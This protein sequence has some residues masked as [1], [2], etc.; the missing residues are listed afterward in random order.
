[1]GF[2]RP[3]GGPEEGAVSRRTGRVV[4]V[5]VR[6]PVDGVGGGVAVAG[7]DGD[8]RGGDGLVRAVGRAVDILH[9]L[10]VGIGGGGDIP[11]GVV[12]TGRHGD[13]AVQGGGGVGGPV[14]P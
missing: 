14:R 4:V 11:R 5:N 13:L 1:M 12:G 3:A 10:L 2:V 7:A 6:F 8:R 9:H